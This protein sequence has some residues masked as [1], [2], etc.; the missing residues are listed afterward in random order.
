MIE[1]VL[2]SEDLPVADRFAWWR[3]MTSQTLTPTEITSD[4]S[5]DFR[6][7]F[8]L[9][10]LGAAQVSVLSYPSLRSRRTPALVR[11]SDPEL[12][13]LALTLRG[14][15]SISRCRRDASVGVGD[16]LLYDSSHP[17]DASAFPDDGSAVEGIVVNVPRTA[18]PLPAAK[19]D[20]LL[21]SPL[22]GDSGM[23]ALLSQFLIRLAPE[24]DAYRP[25]DAIRLGG[26]TVDLITAFLAHHTDTEDSAP[27]ESR[28]QALL[29]GIHSFIECNLTDPQLSPAIVAA[30]HHISV[31]YLHKLFQG[32]SFTVS[33]WIRQRRLEGCRRDL[34]DLQLSDKPIGFLAA[35]WG[36]VHAS[37]F[38]RAFRRAYGV[39]PSTYRHEALHGGQLTDRRL[40]ASRR[41]DDLMPG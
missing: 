41:S 11:R 12:Y 40:R 32:Q 36:Y 2:R 21:G 34:A 23:G 7:C 5:D 28:Q 19:V 35:R 31:R 22:P 6:A 16:L 29:A 3:E 8:R 26:L 13:H 27:P 37:E 20:R 33:A 9:L 14:R 25:Q 24:S 4:H 17:S 39:P 1:T 38:T 18:I 10:D 15:Q 30:S